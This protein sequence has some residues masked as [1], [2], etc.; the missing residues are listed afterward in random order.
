MTPL[1]VLS[2]IQ[3]KFEINLTRKQ[4]NQFFLRHRNSIKKVHSFPQKI[5]ECDI[6]N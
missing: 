2:F 1:N 6:Q 3:D 4:F 5:V